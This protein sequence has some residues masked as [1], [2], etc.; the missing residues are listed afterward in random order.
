MRKTI[1]WR[2]LSLA[3]I[4]LALSGHG[5]AQ[6]Q[7]DLRYGGVVNDYTTNFD[8]GGAW[9]IMGEWTMSVKGDS[10]KGAFTIGF[11]KTT[12]E[13]FFTRIR[14]SGAKRVLDVRLNNVSQLAGFA[15]K[16][17]LRY[18]LRAICSIERC[19]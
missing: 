13:R 1:V 7:R 12:A 10:G 4:T 19:A 2:L 16:D 14:K 5:L 6:G 3:V 11:T 15:K 17:D 8:G 18:F 9:H